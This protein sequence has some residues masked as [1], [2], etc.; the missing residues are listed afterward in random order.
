MILILS[1]LLIKNQDNPPHLSEI[2][3]LKQRLTKLRTNKQNL[4]H[5]NEWTELGS[6]Q[7]GKVFKGLYKQE[8]HSL[9][10]VAIKVRKFK[11]FILQ[12]KYFVI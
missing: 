5:K 9:M 3:I 6:G 2:S 4:N 10:Q 1:R 8:D 12:F 11:L 7:F